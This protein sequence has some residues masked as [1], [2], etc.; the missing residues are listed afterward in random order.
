[1]QS[2]EST[3]I[4]L[5]E[6]FD[7]ETVETPSTIPIA[8]LLELI[9]EPGPPPLPFEYE[10]AIID[11]ERD[12]DPQPHISKFNPSKVLRKMREIRIDIKCQ[13]DTG[14][15]V[16]ATHD[17]RIL[18]NYRTLATPIQIITYSK[19][20]GNDNPC[21]AIGVGQCKTVSNDNTVMYW[22]ML[23]T[24]H[25]T[26]TIL[27]PDKYMMDNKTVDT[28]KHIGNKNGTG[29]I[30]FENAKGRIIAAIDMA[31]HHDGLWYTT[32]PVLLPPTDESSTIPTV[33][34]A[35]PTINKTTSAHQPRLQ[36]IDEQTPIDDKNT[37][38]ATPTTTPT[39]NLSKSLEQLELWHQRMGHP[40]QRALHQ[41]QKVVEGIPALPPIN[42][43]FSCPFCDMAKLRKSN[44]HKE[45][46]REVFT[47][48]TSFHMDLGFIR[49]PSNLEDVVKNG[50]TPSK[51]IVKSRDGYE[52]YLLIVDAATR[53]I[54]VFLL[55]GKHP[56]IAT[57]AQFL[58]KHGTAHKGTITTTPGGLLAKSRSFKTT[59]K[60]I[61]YEC[62]TLDFDLNME[63]TG[64][65]T[66]RHTIRTD[67]G[68]ELAGSTDFCQEIANHGYL[69]EPTAPDASNQNGLA[70]R[71]HKTLKERVR[72]LLYTASLGILFWADALLHAVWLYNRTYHSRIEK[73]P[74]Q[75]YT[76][77]IPTLDGLLTFG[78]RVTPKKAGRRNTAADPNSYDGIFL[79]Y[80][81]TQDNIRYWDT[82][83]QRERSATH[84]AKD[85]VQY[86]DPPE[87]RSP[88][89][90][91]LIAV[92]TGTP[93]E[94]RRTDIL[95]DNVKTSTK[96]QSLHTE[97][98]TAPNHNL[99]T[100]DDSPLPFTASAAK[101]KAKHERQPE[102]ILTHELLLMD[103]T[104]NIH[105]PAVS[106]TLPLQGG[107]P[108]LG[109]ITEQHPE[110]LD[111]IT[112]TR[113]DP[114]TVSHK[115]IRRWKSRLR[116]STIRMVD[117][118]TITDNEQFTET[119]RLK[120]LTGQLHVKIQ[121]ANPR[122]S[123]MS[124]NGLPTL[125]FDQLNVI[126][127]HLNAINSDGST[128]NDPI[129]W[130][131]LDNTNIIAA[132][133]K[134]L[135]LPKLSRR[136]L[137][138]TPAWPKFKESEWTQ[139]NKYNKQGMFGEPC[140]RPLDDDVVVLPWVWSYLY[141]I[142]P[143]TIEDVAKSRGTCNGGP[144][145]GKVITI[146]ETYAACVEQPAHRLMWALLAALNFVGLGIDVGNAFAE[147]P[148]P[149]DPFFMQA[150]T[151]FREW[152]TQ[153][154]GNPPIP[155][156]WVI[157]ILKNLQGH[158][159][160]PRLWDTHIRGIMCKRLGFKATTHEQCFYFKRTVT[161]GLILI[162]RQV[163]D[164][165]IGAKHMT[166][167]QS[168]RKEIQGHMANPLNDLGI[169]KRFNGVDIVQTRHYN[170]VHCR[171]YIT[172]ITEHH[173]WT[174]EKAPNK[175]VP[176]KSDSTYLATLQLAEGPESMREQQQLEDSMGFSY[177]QAI[178]ELI[179]ALTICR[180]DI[181]VAVITLSQYSANPAKEH[182]QAAKA[183]FVYLWHTREDGIY[184]WR[185]EPREDLPDIPLPETTT[186]P[187]RLKA[188]L[189]FED[190]LIAKGAGDST[191]ASD[192]KHRRSMGGIVFMI[193]GGA[194]YYR[195]RLQP[196]VAQSS[197]EAE[198]CNMVDA[199]KAALYLR[200]ILDEVGIE[201]ILPTEI[202]A[203]NKGARQLSNARQPTRR[204]R[205]VDM[206]QFVILQWTEEERIDYSEVS[207]HNNFS[208]SL[209]KPTGRVKFYEHN[210]I[211]MGRRRPIYVKAAHAFKMLLSSTYSSLKPFIF[212]SVPDP[213][214]VGR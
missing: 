148:P 100:I 84:M 175:P 208:D 166:T 193:A 109:L 114:G 204:T 17:R 167:C 62:G 103:I 140:P 110:Y 194:I 9:D 18:W 189:N 72:C 158:P 24:P 41:T 213:A 212:Q 99:M 29:S 32:N 187:E 51:T 69:V 13:G 86:G 96:D 54:W 46:L 165:I 85:E 179:F 7:L 61:G 105:E 151:Q 191:W 173:G 83:A 22:T 87:R 155:E 182:Y 181:S 75:A 119:I 108:T 57:I 210:D 30:N 134:G 115:Q 197:T 70:E 192:R 79:G 4:G 150:D 78:C 177:R 97:P 36:T 5:E 133:H 1:M 35:T 176:M 123:A 26:G 15:N 124:G 48:G 199:G 11:L 162:L 44:R 31:R 185:P 137:L 50:A 49:G 39:I 65:E 94:Q 2:T 159:E 206:K 102:D 23:H 19:D 81:A 16:G 106:E 170:K 203:D 68:G 91:H 157:P 104:T 136:R 21:Q 149:K 211:M 27:S 122:W 77:R 113:C 190:P 47:P 90:K 112:L 196:T 202:L 28:F 38:I 43:L 101:V 34:M 12:P 63:D 82:N 183:V 111:T 143:I 154:L 186:D 71:P 131:P 152:W 132:V 188:F 74:F 201:Q 128:W 172:R 52:A 205:H 144:R 3:D 168:I 116:G 8:D 141:K 20:E 59:C 146:A 178:G 40:A 163:D 198:F 55:K 195:T 125:Q 118:I 67:N 76:K 145:H 130:P 129:Q 139:L 56:P 142:D 60:E 95:L 121:F 120:R 93:H 214:S 107:H 42:S 161:D 156:G 98:G 25:S 14:A 138:D 135:A 80:R 153:C 126:T 174:N 200:S 169:I 147:A 6:H 37:T 89:S 10:P 160:G 184:Y 33:P 53:Y 209:T 66:P 64:L 58:E 92:I 207:T 45:S 180:I 88:A 127:H 164:F 171:T 117:D 73:T